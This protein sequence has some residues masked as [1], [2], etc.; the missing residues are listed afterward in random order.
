MKAILHRL[1][2]STIEFIY[3]SQIGAYIHKTKEGHLWA[4]KNDYPFS[5]NIAMQMEARWVSFNVG[6]TYIEFPN[7]DKYIFK[8]HE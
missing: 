3:S 2:G 4:I 1:D 8:V 5:F 7:G 6:A